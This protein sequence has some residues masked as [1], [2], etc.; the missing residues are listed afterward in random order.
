M[1]RGIGR[2]LSASGCAFALREVPHP[3]DIGAS[4]FSALMDIEILSPTRLVHHLARRVRISFVQRLADAYLQAATDSLPEQSVAAVEDRDAGLSV[5]FVESTP[6]TVG[7]EVLVTEDVEDDVPDVDGLA[8][9]VSRAAL[10][11][12]AHELARWH[13]ARAAAETEFS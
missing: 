2:V 11:I 4:P 3:A 1:T 9:D 5:T 8:F 13:D 12:A 10:V 6:F 7:I